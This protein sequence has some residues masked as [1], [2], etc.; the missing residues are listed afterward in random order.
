VSLV[1][2]LYCYIKQF[3]PATRIMVSGL[4]TKDGECGPRCWAR[5]AR[6]LFSMSREN[7][8]QVSLNVTSGYRSAC[9]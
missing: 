3:H 2:K 6:L 5:R 9:P 1:Q 8:L 4:R 7:Y